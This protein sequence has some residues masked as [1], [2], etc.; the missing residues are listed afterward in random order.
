MDGDFSTG[1]IVKNMPSSAGD[2]GSIPSQSL[3]DETREKP[4]CTTTKESLRPT[5]KTQQSEKIKKKIFFC[6]SVIVAC[7]FFCYLSS[8]YQK[9]LDYLAQSEISKPMKKQYS[10]NLKYFTS[11]LDFWKCRQCLV[12]FNHH[13]LNVHD[14]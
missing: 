14:I 11:V 12:V 8:K 13:I 6:A 9:H 10:H 3:R 4:I 2:V 5:T 1:P 7:V